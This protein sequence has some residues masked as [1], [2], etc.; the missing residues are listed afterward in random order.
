M[1]T[2]LLVRLFPHFLTSL[3]GIKNLQDAIT[4]WLPGGIFHSKP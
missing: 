1:I 2:N 4:L 3:E